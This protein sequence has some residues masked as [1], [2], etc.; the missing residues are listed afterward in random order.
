MG[1]GAFLEPLVVISLLV[2]GTIIN[3]ETDNEALC[4][5]ARKRSDDIEENEVL[6]RRT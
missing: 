1:A 5:F 6:R 3:R 2:G 4:Q